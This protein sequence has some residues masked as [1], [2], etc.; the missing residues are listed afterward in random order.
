MLLDPDSE[1]FAGDARL[2]KKLVKKEYEAHRALGD[3]ASLMGKYDVAAEEETIRKVLAERRDLN[4]EMPSPDDIAAGT[5]FAGLFARL[6]GGPRPGYAR[7][8]GP[9]P[10]R[11]RVRLRARLLP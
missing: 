3:W 1:E 7:S 5:D 4:T 10:Q 2:L 9:L 6:S 8:R 11:G